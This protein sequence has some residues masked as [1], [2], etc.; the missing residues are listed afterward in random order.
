[1]R[2]M[3]R[4]DVQRLSHEGRMEERRREEYITIYIHVYIEVG[5]LGATFQPGSATVS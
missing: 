2:H 3:Q 1:M 5:M 4:D